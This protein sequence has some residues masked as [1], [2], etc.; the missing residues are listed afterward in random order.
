[1]SSFIIETLPSLNL[2]EIRG[3]HMTSLKNLK[4]CHRYVPRTWDG[5]LETSVIDGLFDAL[6]RTIS[7]NKKEIP[8]TN[9]NGEIEEY[10][11]RIE[12]LK[13]YMKWKEEEY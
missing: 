1:M 9:K 3:V 8:R 12:E 4:R 7:K 10:K 2:S 6:E 11:T 5:K 13:Q